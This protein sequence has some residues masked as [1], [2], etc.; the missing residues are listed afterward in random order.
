MTVVHRTLPGCRCRGFTLLELLVVLV[1]IG[2]ILT[3]AVLSIGDG[4]R[5]DRLEQEARRL[6]A[7]LTLTG[8]EAVLR[9]LELG[10]V[11]KRQGYRFV[12]FDGEKWQPVAGDA[13]LR[14]HRLPESMALELFIDGLPVELSLLPGEG[15]E[16]EE[17]PL[18]QLLFFSSG[19]RQPF[20]LTVAYRDG[21]PLSYRLQGPL[22]G[23]LQLARV[24]R[25]F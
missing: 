11:L 17:G 6:Q 21:E 9:S 12:A 16:D 22:L 10:V 5:R 18:P 20:E 24:E 7:L 14:E 8:E 13:L 4:G 3:F 1:I 2:I 25:Q 19:E 15:E 23:P